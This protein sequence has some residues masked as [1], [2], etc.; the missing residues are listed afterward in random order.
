MT[1]EEFDEKVKFFDQMAMSSW[2][3]AIHEHFLD[4]LGTWE[5]KQVLD[6][7]CGT[8]RLLMKGTTKSTDVVGID[9]SKNMIKHAE[10]LFT[11]SVNPRSFSFQVADAEKLPFHEQSFDIVCSTCV[12]FLIPDPEK[13]VKEMFRVLKPSGCLGLINP[14]SKLNVRVAEQYVQMWNLQDIEADALIQWG[15][16]SERRHT[17]HMNEFE[18]LLKNC[19]FKDVEQFTYLEDLSLITIAQK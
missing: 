3:S 12:V 6:V 16:I 4:Q 9:L 7:G 19:G 1:G 11:R 2:L 18:Q 5:D 15:R 8:G 13:V 17:F 10:Q 14:S